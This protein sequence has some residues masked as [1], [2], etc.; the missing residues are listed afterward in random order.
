MLLHRNRGRYSIGVPVKKTSFKRF[1]FRLSSSLVIIAMI[2]SVVNSGGLSNL[3]DNWM[4]SHQSK[5]TSF[6]ADKPIKA[7]QPTSTLQTPNV[8]NMFS[9]SLG[10]QLATTAKAQLG[11][12]PEDFRHIKLLA[13]DRS[14]NTRAYLNADGT[15]SVV[16]TADATSYKD[17]AGNW[18]NIDNTLVEGADGVW[19]TKANSWIASFGNSA[20]YGVAITENGSTFREIPQ[21]ADSVDPS[22][23]TDSTG[24]Q[25]VTYKN[26]W[27]GIDLTYKVSGSDVKESIIVENK[28]AATNYAFAY[29]GANL[30]PVPNAP[31][32]YALDGVFSGLEIA[33]PAVT[34]HNKGFVK[35]SS[36]VAQALNGNVLTVSLGSTW[37]SQLSSTAFPL[38]IDPTVVPIGNNYN[39][40]NNVPASCGPGQGC[41]NSVG[42]DQTGSGDTWRFIYNAAIPSSPGQY[43]ISAQLALT[44]LAGV[45]NSTTITVDHAS[46]TNSINCIDPVQSN[47]GQVTGQIATSGPLELQSMYNAAIS[48]G[49]TN[50]NFIVSG[51]DQTGPNSYK[52]FDNTKTS[53]TFTY[54]TLPTPSTAVAADAPA[55]GGYSVSTQPALDATGATGSTLQYRYI[56][57]NST[58]TP[59][60]DPYHIQ[61]SVTD[62]VADSGLLP[63]SEWVVPPGV[64]Q[65]GHKYYW[66]QVVWDGHTGSPQVYGPAY[67]FTVNL[68]NGQDSTQAEDSLGPVN[69]DF[70]TGDVSTTNATHSSK[71]LGGDL[72]LGLNYNTPQRSGPG[73]T[74]Q[75]Y[76][77]T[78]TCNG[79]FPAASV[80]PTMTRTDPNINFNWG[81]SSPYPGVVNTTNYYVKW[82][83]YFVA[84][85]ADTYQFGTTSVDRSQIFVNGSQTA[86]VNGWSS[87]PTN[88][89]GST[90]TLTAGQI[91]PIT[92]EYEELTGSSAAQLLVKTSD[93][94][95]PTETVPTS[96]LQTGAQPIAISNGLVGTYY[97]DDGTHTFDSSSPFLTRTDTSMNLNWGANA[98][99]PNGPTNN[100]IVKWV[101]YFT[102]T[103]TDNYTFGVGSNGGAQVLI[104]GT[105]VANGWNDHGPSPIIYGSSA[106]YQ[107]GVA[108]PITVEYYNDSS[109]GQMGVYLKQQ[110]LQQQTDTI[111]NSS[112]LT[113]GNQVLPAGW[114]TSIDAGGS[115]NYDFATI[116]QNSV[117]LYD[118]NGDTHVYTF[119]NGGFTPPAGEAG[120]MTRNGDGTI[121][122]QDSDGQTYIFNVDGTIKSVTSATDDLHP[123]AL[124]YL[125]GS[126]SGSPVHLQQI[127]DGV[128]S[129]RYAHVYYTGSSKC[130]AIPSGYV[131]GPANMIC[132]VQTNDGRLTY[133]YYDVNGNLARLSLP[134][135]ENTDYGYT[136]ATNG[137]GQTVG[138][139]LSSTRD[140]LANDA[141]S[142][143]IRA[144][145]PTTFTQIGYD[146]LGRATS[147]TSP[148][149]TTGGTPL[150]HTYQYLPG[151]TTLM[152]V[153]NATEPNGFTREVKYDGTDRTTDDIDVN[154]LD[155]KTVWDPAKDLVDSTTDPTGME[156]TYL[157]DYGNR[158]TDTYG[159][160]PTAW[161]DNT[162]T[163]STYHTPLSSYTSQVP[164]E[165]TAYDQ[166]IPG[167]AATYYDV[168]MASNGTGSTTAVLTGSPTTGGPKLHSTGIGPVNG[169]INE[170]WNGTPPFTP[171]S[172]DGWG[173]SL[174][175]DIDLTATGTYA[176][177][178]YSN[179]GVRLWV[180]DT[181]V[182]NDWN[183]G[184]P[185]SHG[186]VTGYT[187]FS[188]TSSSWHR[189]RLQ[190]YN[191][192]GDTNAVLQLYMTPP[193]GSETSSLGSLLTPMYGLATTQTTYDS[194]SSVGNSVTTNNYGPNPELGL[195]QSSTV[196]PTGLNL[197]TSYTYEPK[198]GTGSLLRELSQTLP[199]GA[200]TSYSYYGAT[201]SVPNPCYTSQTYLQ[202]GMLKQTT[203]PTGV[204]TQYVYDDAGNVIAQQKNSDPW[205]CF[206]FDARNRMTQDAIP[207]NANGD[208]RTL[209][210]SY[211]TS[212][213]PLM[214]S[215]SDNSGALQT[216][217]DLLGRTVGYQDSMSNTY[218]TG[219]T[220]TAYDTLGRTSTISSP[221]FGTEKITYDNY[222]RLASESLDGTN[223]ATPTYDAYSRLS[224]VA[225]PAASQLKLTVGYDSLGRTNSNSTTLGN[226]ST[227]PADAVTLSQ[228][229]DVVS[230]TELGQA[231]TYTYDKDDRLTAAT[232]FGN[233]YAYSFA[234][235]TACTGTYSANAG[236]DSDRTSQT[237]NGTTTSYCYNTADQLISSSNDAL[238]NDTYDQYGNMTELGDFY[239]TSNVQFAYDSSGRTGLVRQYSGGPVN[240]QYYR[241]AA[242]RIV[243]RGASGSTEGSSNEYFGY[244]N[245]SDDPSYLLN[246]SA[247]LVERYLELP[248]GV[249]LTVRSGST[250]VYSLP[251]VQGNVMATANQ[252]GS[253][254]VGFRNDPFGQPIGTAPSN[255]SGNASYAAHGSAQRLTESAFTSAITDMGARTYIPAIGRFSS[256][257]PVENGN[258]NA[259]VYPQDPVNQSDD[260]GDMDD[261]IAASSASNQCLTD[262][263]QCLA[264]ALTVL[265]FVPLDLE[266]GVSVLADEGGRLGFGPRS[267]N[268]IQQDILRGKAPST[269]IRADRARIANEI[270][271]I[272][273]K[274]GSA[275]NVDGTWKHGGKTLS[276]IELKYLRK[277]GWK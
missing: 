239:N 220:T 101:G 108:Y 53:V 277:I 76:N 208:A 4:M 164:H 17:Q 151:N 173:A 170:T 106:Q 204:T 15:K 24:T 181:L 5:L 133:F 128:T 205:E 222:N 29:S 125:Y 174:T 7:T 31:G 175:G 233:T 142:A 138:Y 161:F 129:N 27:N 203:D 265:T 51:G 172:G 95:V 271:H 20:T 148:E 238:T 166:N 114:S 99:V 50:P 44:E 272:H 42:Y 9:P 104:S 258:A 188:N 65:D 90:M 135:S 37:F 194:S 252:S 156:T 111:I 39:N 32:S 200:T 193:G 191:A 118:S 49:D 22:V 73:L 212:G 264:D 225:Y 211:A 62:V 26:L 234:T 70:A 196:D 3:T 177:R 127:T 36:A 60:N 167:L 254:V 237:I 171:D 146:T 186:M 58:T 270:D 141:V 199:G 240:I 246:T 248:G 83:G 255:V 91:V 217:T 77:C 259:Y 209:T 63:Q 159:P 262:P 1:G 92:Y 93:N 136:A 55:N 261:I 247:A 145:D 216:T 198:G 107:K 80:A 13:T 219:T 197:T 131:V 71:S 195:L 228:S 249:E 66:E 68:R 47:Y 152:H 169:D 122:L 180:D 179:D 30:T 165:Q 115:T 78:G 14:A 168:T 232:L 33:A 183:N 121:T 250:R 12:K 34:T 235:P 229:G 57:G 134:G 147:V 100:Y 263:D 153:V 274:G 56:I 61:P 267:I 64:L 120:H 190:Y 81:S 241:D 269:M 201:D 11:G 75:Y 143:G 94:A 130:G 224:S 223:Y 87:D 23:E 210:Y 2:F 227:G 82:T 140:S 162:P 236:K 163:D 137:A 46:C 84:P 189:M 72:G 10:K 206:T 155:T 123:T 273:F 21:D 154:N 105:Q 89:Y 187:G 226:G 266:G 256:V 86:Y 275:L 18:Q 144:N 8:L 268:Q 230:G 19:H 150:E 59:T 184:A 69:V 276:N 67:S 231:K 242:D 260:T 202:A 116:D 178:I 74:G 215:I 182:I 28:D 244:T 110:S 16:Y 158:L 221:V 25:T 41:G 160:A 218:S 85:I 6:V 88:L 251:D 139:E 117:T 35:D 245:G 207:A 45:T 98:P 185:R 103:V 119:S 243:Y 113:P 109:N 96:M 257:D 126:D 97:P 192:A 124:Q 52:E 176:F 149:A 38:V 40:F 112:L 79:T 102:P 43:L 54:E 132:A 213:N 253:S 214:T 157:Y 48:R